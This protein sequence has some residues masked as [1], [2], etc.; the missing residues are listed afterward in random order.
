MVSR[1]RDAEYGLAAHGSL[2]AAAPIASTRLLPIGRLPPTFDFGVTRR[3]GKQ[4]P[5][6]R[7][8]PRTIDA[9]EEFRT[10]GLYASQTA[11]CL[12]ICSS[13]LSGTNLTLYSS[14][15]TREREE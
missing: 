4:Q 7:R 2:A 10:S 11:V 13:G 1:I 3:R 12:V 5:L 14:Y 15:K 8:K 6:M 9:W